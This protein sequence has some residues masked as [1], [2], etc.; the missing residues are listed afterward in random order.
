MGMDEMR[1]SIVPER[2]IPSSGEKLK[3]AIV[4]G[5]HGCKAILE[6]VTEGRMS[7]FNLEI[8][9]VVDPN[10]NSA[11]MLFAKELGIPTISLIEDIL[12]FQGLELVIELT[13][14][15][16]IFSEIYRLVPPG[17]KILD[18]TV[19]RV[20]WDLNEADQILRRQ[21]E[22]KI[23]LEKQ[24]KRDQKQLQ[25]IIN[26]LGD[27]II[28]MNQ[29]V[30]IEAVNA[31][32]I[33]VTGVTADQVVGQECC[34]LICEKLGLSRE[35]KNSCRIRELIKTREPSREIHAG[36]A[37]DG[38]ETYYEVSAVP[39]FD[40]EGRVRRVVETF[41]RITEQVQLKRE[42]Q[43]TIQ[44]FQ[45]FIDS[46]HDLIFMKDMEGRYM[47]ISPSAAALFNLT[48]EAF[49][50]KT[51]RNLFGKKIAEMF[52]K[53]DREIIE[54][55]NHICYEETL[56]LNGKRYHLNTV[57]FPL[58]DYKGDCI[59]VCVISRDISEQKR[60][61]D[62]LI[63]S[64]KLAALG[65]LAAGVA[66]EINNP[67]S[68]ILAFVEDLLVDVAPDDPVKN[69]YEVIRREALRCRQIVK[70]LLDYTRLQK[71]VR[72]PE[73][74]NQIVQRVFNIVSKQA[75][76]RNIEFDLD[77]CS[78]IKRANIDSSQ[79]QQVILNLV[80]N[81]A[82]AMKGEGTIKIDSSCKEKTREIEL[83]ISD[84]GF[85]IKQED[86]KKIFEPFF[87]TKGQKGNGLGLPVVLSIVE[88]HGG[89]VKVETEYGKGTTFRIV[90][91]ASEEQ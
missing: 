64:E 18:H 48:P 12:E 68:G 20:F 42:T 11:G 67:L 1:D 26:S 79:M 54:S 55:G 61:Q 41:H 66:H 73:D 9:C 53:K 62:D 51:D 32:F 82:D 80:I 6:M 23:E 13:G 30:I 69:D 72:Q 8:V 33:K 50:G 16:N 34:G 90:L 21:L 17:I 29:D 77:L 70:D 37:L 46:T 81:A 7:T 88:Q 25:D 27:A 52:F 63:Q 22:E 39:V 59:G 85:G 45:Q 71:S 24:L 75:A 15:N 28:V 65:K 58:L 38:E 84:Q 19:A 91:P 3:T 43:E 35:H 49:I 31:E 78:N 60:L 57:R 86:L 87:S 40:E 44:R 74:I 47:L 76:F 4:G 36:R 2:I 10:Q 5:G 14:R 56:V 89:N 83:T